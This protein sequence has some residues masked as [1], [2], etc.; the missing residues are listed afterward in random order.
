MEE[1]FRF[2]LTL[3]QLFFMHHR[4]GITFSLALLCVEK[5]FFYQNQDDVVYL[6]L[7]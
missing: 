3:T 1:E 7:I 4:S 2:L 6:A 5:C